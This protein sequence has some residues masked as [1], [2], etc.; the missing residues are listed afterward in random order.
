MF[1]MFYL[2]IKNYYTENDKIYSKWV[3]DYNMPI[4]TQDR[5]YVEQFVIFED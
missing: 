3:I 1:S 2:T 4:L 5:N